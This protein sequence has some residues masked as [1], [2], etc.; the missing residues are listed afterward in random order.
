MEIIALVF[1][2]FVAVVLFSAVRIVPQQVSFVIERFGKYDRTFNAGLHIIVPF[3]DRV[4]YKHTLKE[5]VLDIPEQLCITRDNVQVHVDGV[6]FLRV[7]DPSRASYGVSNYQM[8]VVQLAQTTLRSEIGKLDLD[9]TFEERENINNS[10]VM[11]LDKATDAWGAKV[12]RYEVKSIN[13]PRDVIEAME[14]QMRAEREKR[15]KILES[16]GDRDSKI[17][18]ADGLKQETIK[19]SEATKQRQINEAEGQAQAIL[20]VAHATAKGLADVAA[21]LSAKGGAEAARLRVAED[22]VKQFGKLAKSTNSMIIPA[23]AA[24]VGSVM[25]T[26]FGVFDGLR[27][28]P[29][30]SA[31]ETTEGW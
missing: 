12:L 3:M 14:K 17:N 28:P 20:A 4:A 1:L 27:N 10:I 22:W 7:M 31:A 29:K 19:A 30:G 24:D 2:G 5:L 13:P 8:A 15:A 18:R 9:R 21:A 25:A 11:A 6:I 16:E 23:N 26:A